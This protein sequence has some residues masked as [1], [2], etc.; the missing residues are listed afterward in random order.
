THRLVDWDQH[1]HESRY[2][3]YAGPLVLSC[4]ALVALA[5]VSRVLAAFRGRTAHATPSWRLAAIPSAAFLLQEHLE[6][7][8]H[9]GSV[10]WATTFEPTVLIGVVLQL[11]FGFLALWLV[12]SLLRLAHRAGRALADRQVQPWPGPRVCRA[13]PVELPRIT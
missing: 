12:R 4:A 2:V 5:V 11:P 9:Y 8:H 3:E 13:H 6:R 1:A 10:D 7:L